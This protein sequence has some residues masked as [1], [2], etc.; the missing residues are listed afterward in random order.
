MLNLSGDFKIR[1]N[2]PYLG[3]T[4]GLVVYLSKKFINR[5]KFFG[6][7][8]EFNQALI[9]D[10][11]KFKKLGEYLAESIKNTLKGHE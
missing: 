8:L 9:K 2:Y 6:I 5:K 4:D 1:F 11:V 10:K 7:C 3:V